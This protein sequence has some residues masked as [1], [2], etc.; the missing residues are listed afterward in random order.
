MSWLPQ[1]RVDSVHPSE[2][3]ESVVSAEPV[4]E[5]KKRGK[6]APVKRERKGGKA[7]AAK[8]NIP[9][10]ELEA[11]FPVRRKVPR[12]PADPAPAEVPKVVGGGVKKKK[13]TVLPDKFK[14]PGLKIIRQL[15]ACVN[16]VASA[17]AHHKSKPLSNESD[18]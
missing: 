2:D 13:K 6:K 10:D 17:Y 7:K 15:L 3:S 18:N 5:K 4:G 16:Q 1:E 14:G 12:A 11:P 8:L 9:Q